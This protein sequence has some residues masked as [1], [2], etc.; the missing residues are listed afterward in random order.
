MAFIPGKENTAA[1]KESR[2]INLDT[3]W[4]LDPTA[5]SYALSRLQA[6]PDIELFASR[7]NKQFDRCVSYRPDPNAIRTN[8]QF[9]RCVSY[10]PDPNAIR[11][12]WVIS[13]LA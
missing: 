3:E 9:D 5:L 1:D 13:L 2:A 8:K 11:S 6:H 7:T 10:R 4:K 12:G